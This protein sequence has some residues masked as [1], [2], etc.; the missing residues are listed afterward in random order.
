[1]HREVV[2]PVG[3]R[4]QN[5]K[6]ESRKGLVMKAYFLFTAGGPRVILTSDDSVEN[7]RVL[8]RL[9]S[10]GISKFI[11]CEVPVELAKAKHGNHFNV[12][13]QDPKETDNLR[14]L[15]YNGG[16]VYKTFTFKELGAPIYHEESA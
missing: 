8:K 9:Q 11:A 7:P 5:G 12:V 16:R 3:V 6:G 15:D 10:K 13:C 1:M 14:V 4:R 2:E